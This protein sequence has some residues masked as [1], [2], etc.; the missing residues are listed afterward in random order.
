[1]TDGRKDHL[2]DDKAK[3]EHQSWEQAYRVNQPQKRLAGVAVYQ[4]R[5]HSANFICLLDNDFPLYG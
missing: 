4:A 2:V 3:K 5:T 1:A